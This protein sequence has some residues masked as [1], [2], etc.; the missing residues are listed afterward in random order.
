[1]GDQ[2]FVLFN[3]CRGLDLDLDLGLSFFVNRGLG[4]IGGRCFNSQA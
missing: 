2:G 3:I 1:L 4:A